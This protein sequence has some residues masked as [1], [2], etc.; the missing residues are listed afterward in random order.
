MSSIDR[1]KLGEY[2]SAYL[3]DEL[4]AADR[5]AVERLV[6]DDSRARA[7]LDELR[8]TVGLVHDLPRR[9]APP[10]LL[11]D[12]TAAV[13]R[14]ELLGEPSEEVL[15]RRPWWF[16]L[17]PILS[18]AAALV[19][20]IGGG[21]WVYWQMSQTPGRPALTDAGPG[22]AADHLGEP[23]D[24][25]K[26]RM[27]TASRE[28]DADTVRRLEALGYVGGSSDG[29]S[30]SGASLE[31]SE[32]DVDTLRSQGYLDGRRGGEP[33]DRG[34]DRSVRSENT[35]PAATPVATVPPPSIERRAVADAKA[36]STGAEPKDDARLRRIA[37][38]LNFQ[39]KAEAGLGGDA[40]A[41]HDFSN[42]SNRLTVVVNGDEDQRLGASQLTAFLASNGYQDAA[43]ALAADALLANE[44][45][46][47]EGR[48]GLNYRSRGD[49]QFLVR[50]PAE[51]LPELVAAVEQGDGGERKM[52]MAIGP[53][54]AA[55][56]VEIERTIH[57]I[58]HPPGE[59]LV[60]LDEEWS[61]SRTYHFG[62]AHEKNESAEKEAAT[63]H[64][65]VV[66]PVLDEQEPASE[67]SGA[68]AAS[69]NAPEDR[70]ALA[71]EEQKPMGLEPAAR[72]TAQPGPTPARSLGLF[73]DDTLGQPHGPTRTDES[74]PE[75]EDE[76]DAASGGAPPGNLVESQLGR[77]REKRDG[78]AEEQPTSDYGNIGTAT[79][80]FVTLIVQFEQIPQPITHPSQEQPP[81]TPPA[82]TQ[83]APLDKTSPTEP[84]P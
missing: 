35:R 77:L 62:E 7:L 26:G 68:T 14:Q 56:P 60:L 70:D 61:P 53:L 24:K 66:P 40:L 45:S 63:R 21:Y 76:G 17:R 78:Y 46:Y 31:M 32:D 59:R 65:T 50:L 28:M 2:L 22:A 47:L 71:G 57:Q 42:E 52:E 73:F 54:V 1:E 83:P 12:L 74:R 29:S 15:P 19:I 58:Q 55:G 43:P 49:S 79:E 37:G 41:D 9:T 25:N 80:R 81:A 3:D 72:S 23:P 84:R 34:V 67:A 39:Q 30:V 8:Q 69:G 18:A 82:A 11:E 48:P 20:T 33:E 27:S 16:T 44:R 5:Q 38:A 64:G 10:S 36:S 75:S 13:E 6:A 51:E 4:N